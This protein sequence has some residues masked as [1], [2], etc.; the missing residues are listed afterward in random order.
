MVL[1]PYE[2]TSMCV[3]LHSTRELQEAEK[4]EMVLGY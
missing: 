4:L 1:E 2:T 3:V